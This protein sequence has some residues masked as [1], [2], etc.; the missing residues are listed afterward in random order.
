MSQHASRYEKRINRVC[1]HIYENLDGDL[2]LQALSEAAA[3]SPF[4]FHRV[5][6]SVTGLT[7]SKFIQLARLRRASYRVAFKPEITVTEIAFEAGFESLEAFSR[8]FKREIGQTPS[9]FRAR[10][11]WPQWHERCQFYLPKQGSPPMDVSIVDFP[12]TTVALLEHCGPPDRVLETAAQFIAWR[13]ESGLSPVATSKTF[14]VPHNDPNVTP[15]EEFR[16]DVCGAI[17]GDVPENRYG[18]KAGA[19][20]GGRCAVVRHRGSHAKLDDCIYA[21]YRDWLPHSG[22]ETRDFPCF[23]H[24]VNLIH[25]VEEHL[26]LTDIYLPIK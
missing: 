5:F 24:Y 19:I 26:L 21:L 2:S 11:A 22:E 1:D 17:D 18:V 16:W 3:F 14:G 4:H 15:P 12:H 6:S 13:K 7:V 8:A 10:P 20:P 23:F 25:D 9:Q